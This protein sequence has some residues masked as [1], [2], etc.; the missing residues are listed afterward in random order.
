[1]IVDWHEV[2]DGLCCGN[3]S[4]KEKEFIMPP[5]SL[6]KNSLKE[7]IPSSVL[8]EEWRPAMLAGAP[9]TYIRDMASARASLQEAERIIRAQEDKIRQLEGL[10]LTD[11]LTGLL[12]RRGF[13]LSFQRELA[14]ARRDDNA[15]G[16]LIMVDLDGFK[17]INDMWGHNVGD[18]YLQAVAH[19]LLSTVR[20]SDVV[21]RLGGDEFVILFTRMDEE[22]GRQRLARLEKNFNTRIMQF[23]DNT[24]PLRASFGLSTYSGMDQSEAILAAADH[25]LYANKAMRRKFPR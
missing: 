7:V 19:S 20:S 9:E 25:K 3:Y 4:R 2:C 12:N 1:M 14:V 10:A 24:L 16:V 13:M 11:E 17:T 6:A 5:L 15:T 18:D 8:G 22:T 23:G 21:A